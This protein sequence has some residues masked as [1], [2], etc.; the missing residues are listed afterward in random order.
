VALMGQKAYDQLAALCADFHAKPGI[1]MRHAAD[2]MHVDA[3]VKRP[4]GRVKVAQG[5]RHKK[6]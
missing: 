2:P 6:T 3:T 1:A 5:G 4:N